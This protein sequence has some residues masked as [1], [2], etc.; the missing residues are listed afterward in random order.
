M[1]LEKMQEVKINISGYCISRDKAQ[2]IA[3]V[4]AL[5]E[6]LDP[7]VIAR[8]NRQTN[9]C[10]PCSLGYN[11]GDKPGWQVYGENHGGRIKIDINNGEFV[12]IF[13]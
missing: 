10:S 6:N 8:Y 13:S 11:I 3:R 5:E 4:V 12:F 7:I 2:D 1:V 9:A